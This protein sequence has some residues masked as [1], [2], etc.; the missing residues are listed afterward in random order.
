VLRYFDDCDV[1]TTAKYI[2]LS[3]H[4]T[5]SLPARGRTAFRRD[6]RKITGEPT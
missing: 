4:A 2:G 3:V 1:G 6:Y 5:E